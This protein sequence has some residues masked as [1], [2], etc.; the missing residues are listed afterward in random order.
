MKKTALILMLVTMML[1][2]MIPVSAETT[3]GQDY[4]NEMRKIYEE[5]EAME[6]ESAIELQLS[7]PDA[8]EQNFTIRMSGISDMERFATHMTIEVEA[9]DPELAI[10]TIELYTEGTNFYL[11]Q[12]FVLFLAQ[13]AEME[14][15]LILEEDFVMLENDQVDFQLDSGFLVQIL[16]MLEGMDLEFELD[17]TFEDNTY[18]LSMDA[19]DMIDLLDAYLVYMMTNMEEMAMMMGMPAEEMELTEEEMAEMMEMYEMFVA[20]MMETIKEAIAGSAYEQSTVFEEDAY[21]EVATLFLTTPFGDMYL[22]MDSSAVKLEDVEIDMP[23]SVKV[24]TEEEMTMWMLSGMEV[25]ET[26]YEQQ[27][28]AIID[29]DH[30]RY[31]LFTEHDVIEGEIDVYISDDSRSYMSSADAVELFGLDLEPS[32]EMMAIRELEQFGY[33]VEWDDYSRSIVVSVETVY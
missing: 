15:E 24:I 32:D 9:E 22:T 19:D 21:E 14:D 4:W 1:V 33:T 16:D 8:V 5:W 28:A 31:A 27:P 20:P 13:L 12:E 10:P 18:H 29:I 30:D 26:T 3:P 6:S 11:N 25:E 17:M 2:S 23:T 7:F